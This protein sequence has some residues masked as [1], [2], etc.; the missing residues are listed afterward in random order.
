MMPNGKILC[1]VTSTSSHNPVYFYEF[2][3]LANAFTQ[4]ASPTGGFS[5]GTTISDAMTM[6]VLPDGN[7]LFSDTG[8]HLWV[9]QPDGFPVAAGKPT[10]YDVHWNVNGTLHM[11]GTL[12]NGIS[13]GAAFGD[14]AQMDSNY[15]IIRLT[16]G[17]G[18]V[19]YARTYNWDSTSVMTG[20]RV[21]NTDFA[22]PYSVFSGPGFYS[23]VVV[24]N[25]ISSGAI[26]FY[27][28]VWVDFNYN[29]FFQ[30]GTYALPYHTLGQG[31]SAVA[32]GGTI[33]LK[34]GTSPETMTITK[35]MNITA[36][37]GAATIGH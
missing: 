30:F 36:I 7:I 26:G 33:A 31:V 29:G 15:P 9:Y 23:L 2:D 13:Q 22:L 34:P 14:D 24:A 18:N 11:S 32:S 5:D 16:D 27:G 10:I 17:S 4:V 25:G 8:A 35:P 20:G 12:L 1:V 37:G 21:V 3:Y 19:Y 6:L 28:P